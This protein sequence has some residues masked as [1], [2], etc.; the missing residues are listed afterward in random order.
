M[1]KLTLISA[2]AYFLQNARGHTVASALFL[3]H[4]EAISPPH[5]MQGSTHPGQPI[6]PVPQQGNL[7][8]HLLHPAQAGG[9]HGDA[10]QGEGPPHLQYKEED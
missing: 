7:Q 8:A 1:L 9:P 3:L 4:P 5:S 2:T 6:L 10:A